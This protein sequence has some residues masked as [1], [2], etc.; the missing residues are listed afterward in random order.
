MTKIIFT[1]ADE[2]DGGISLQYDIDWDGGDPKDPPTPAMLRA[3]A[4]KRWIESGELEARLKLLCGPVLKD[5]PKP[6]PMKE[7]QKE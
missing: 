7:P 2:P 5:P 6:Q 4:T 1:F 3:L